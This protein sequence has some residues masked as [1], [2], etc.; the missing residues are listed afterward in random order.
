MKTPSNSIDTAPSLGVEANP[1]VLVHVCIVYTERNRLRQ[2][3]TFNQF[4]LTAASVASNKFDNTISMSP[5]GAGACTRRLRHA[6]AL[7]KTRFASDWPKTIIIDTI[8]DRFDRNT[9][10]TSISRNLVANQ[11]WKQ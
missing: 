1:S 11:C 8:I 4:A 9:V 3:I 2:S 6:G 10:Y 5:D 7:V